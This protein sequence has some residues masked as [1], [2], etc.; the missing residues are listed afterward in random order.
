MAV[1]LVKNHVHPKNILYVGIRDIDPFEQNIIDYY[2]INVI[3]IDELQDNYSNDAWDKISSFIGN[4]PVH[5]SFDVDVLDPSV[6]PSTGTAVEN[7]IQLESCKNIVDK[8]MS[9]NLVS[10]DLTELNLTIGHVEER[11]KSIINFS[12]LFKNYI[13]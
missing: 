5:F 1:H 3:T 10:V 6:L 11:A 2:Q 7:G 9:K 13:F 12:Y 8:M 4:N